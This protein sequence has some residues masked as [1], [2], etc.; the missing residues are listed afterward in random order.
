[1]FYLAT[2][3]ISALLISLANFL[4]AETY[5]LWA[6][7]EYLLITVLGVVAVFAI[8][9]LLAFVI[10][11]LP[12]KWFLP[13]ARMFSVG[14]REKKF[15]RKTKII[16]WKKYVPE[17]GCFT[18]FH[19]DKMRAPND[20]TYIGRFLLESN[21]GVAGHLAGALF[22]FLILPIPLLPTLSIALPI[23]VIN[24]ILSILPTMI[25]RF[26]TP[27]LRGLYRKALER[28]KRKTLLKD[29]VES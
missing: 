5:H 8:D 3:T 13:E 9:G 2:I 19:K 4:F 11:R 7:G 22:G 17:W 28:E 6:F 18:G 14:K 10:R 21:Y 23:A 15:Y 25:L 26:N 1:M 29:T 16:T 24:M 12:E 20:S 27:S